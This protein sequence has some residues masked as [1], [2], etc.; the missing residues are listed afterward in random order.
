MVANNRFPDIWRTARVVAV[1]KKGNKKDIA[2]Y[3]PVSNLC[4]LSKVYERCFL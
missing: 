1:H 4:S 3:R 2:N